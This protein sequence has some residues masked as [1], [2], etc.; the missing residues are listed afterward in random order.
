MGIPICDKCARK[1][2]GKLYDNINKNYKFCFFCSCTI[3][4][5]YSGNRYCIPELANKGESNLE[6]IK[7]YL[8]AEGIR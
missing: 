4:L 8:S 2:L 1:E 6:A 3:C 7:R 5:E